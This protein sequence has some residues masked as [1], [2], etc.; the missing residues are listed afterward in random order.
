METIIQVLKRYIKKT[1][2]VQLETKPWKG[3]EKLPIFLNDLYVFY[4]VSLLEQSC[5]LAVARESDVITPAVIRKHLE[6]IQTKTGI[7]CI[8][9]S[10]FASSYNRKRLIAHR[11]QF[12]IPDRQI[13]LPA[14]GIDW[15]ANCQICQE[16]RLNAHKILTPSAQAVI[17]YALIH[18]NEKEF[19][20]LKLARALNY[21]PMT[22]TRVL[23]ELES[24]GIGK[25]VRNGKERQFTFAEDRSLLW[26]HVMPFMQNPVKKRLWL[27][28]NKDGAREIKR[29]GI[30]AGLS[31][32][33]EFSMLSSPEHP[34]YAISS[35]IWKTLQQS[36]IVQELPS[37]EE[38]QIEL[39]IWSYDPR[40]FAKNGLIDQVSL[41]LSLKDNQNERVEA[42]LKKLIKS[43]KW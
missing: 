27:K 26:A 30:L 11:V 39:E 7:P 16:H 1:L 8:Y 23:N 4:A 38:A 42:A 29:L 41:Y 34:I 20:P 6:E 37:A 19:I 17:I 14:L 15:L 13:Y 35:Q 40:L 3:K 25:A 5:I 32:L 22:M 12:V 9:A 18:Q 2:G 31:A 36:G 43:V 24:F 10:A 28:L 33:A 21:T